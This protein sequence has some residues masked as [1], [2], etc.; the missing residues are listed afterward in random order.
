MFGKIIKISIISI[1][2]LIIVIGGTVG[3]IYYYA[4]RQNKPIEIIGKVKLT[5][6]DIKLGQVV[7]ATIL[8]KC[9]W[10]RRPLEAAAQIA[11]GASLSEAPQ[12]SRES[13]GWGYSV[14]K[15]NT[16]FKAYRTGKIPAGKIDVSYN[17][18]DDKTT[19]L[20]KMF[21]IPPFKCSALALDKKQNIIIA[22][23][24]TPVKMI[25]NRKMY[26][27]IAI[28]AL[29]IIAGIILFIRRHYKK[30]KAVILPS[31]AVAL[32][33]LHSLRNN[34]K[35]G[36]VT[37]DIGF[38]SLTDIVRGYLE[39]RFKLPASKQTTEE[40]LE[41]IN[42]ENGPLPEVQRPFL[43]EFMQASELVKFAKLPPDENILI[44]ALSKAETL[45]N[46]T[47]PAETEGGAE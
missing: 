17:R 40:F 33:D 20:S 15:I 16:G 14:W 12:I 3:G 13:I 24:I 39:K 4:V 34:I 19:D 1:I 26:I 2:T 9:P 35:S 30:I 29:V 7:S 28:I 27:I 47:R 10:H 45:V 6:A 8:L 22:D 37:L 11:P 23:A 36:S 43:K 18:Y 44:Q 38:I 32:N 5:P 46:E 21:I 31:W 25:S 41:G 42:Q